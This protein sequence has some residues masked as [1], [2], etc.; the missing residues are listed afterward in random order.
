MLLL[1]AFGGY[2]VSGGVFLKPVFFRVLIKLFQK[3]GHLPELLQSVRTVP[4]YVAD[5]GQHRVELFL[6]QER[7]QP[8]DRHR[9][10]CHVLANCRGLLLRAGFV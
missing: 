9:Y 4:L 7:L 5:F 1:D 8:D 2:G 6:E 10:H 3:S